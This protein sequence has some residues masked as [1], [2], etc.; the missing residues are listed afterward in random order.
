MIDDVEK[1][2]GKSFNL[3]TSSYFLRA[4]RRAPLTS[5]KQHPLGQGTVES[6]CILD[7]EWHESERTEYGDRYSSW[8]SDEER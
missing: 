1:T 3:Y 6:E 2:P 8:V 4:Q 5:V 7:Y